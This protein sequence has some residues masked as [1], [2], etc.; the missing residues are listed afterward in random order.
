MIAVVLSC[1]VLFLTLELTRQAF[2]E[3]PDWENPRIFG[4]NKEPYHC[5]LLPYPDKA[6]ACIGTRE[7]SPWHQSLNGMWKFH[8]VGQPDHRPRD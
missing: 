1:A 8:W 2:A 4:R 3:T 6:S 7:A 5:T